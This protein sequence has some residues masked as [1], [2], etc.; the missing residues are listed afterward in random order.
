[1]IIDNELIV[2][3]K[4]FDDDSRVEFEAKTTDLG[5]VIISLVLELQDQQNKTAELTKTLTEFDQ[6]SQNDTDYMGSPF[7]KQVLE[8]LDN[9]SVITKE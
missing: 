2:A 5:A 6:Y 9:L 7:R 1:M 4:A 3:D 8:Q